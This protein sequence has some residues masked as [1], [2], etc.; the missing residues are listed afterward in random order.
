MKSNFIKMLTILIYRVAIKHAWDEFL[1]LEV[2]R[3]IACEGRCREIVGYS[4]EL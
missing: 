1:D 3:V 2:G 4:I